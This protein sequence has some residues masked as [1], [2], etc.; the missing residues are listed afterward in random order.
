MA[1][2]LAP[3]EPSVEKAK[4]REKDELRKSIK[5]KAPAPYDED[6]SRTADYDY[7]KYDTILPHDLQALK[8]DVSKQS[9]VSENKNLILIN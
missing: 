3:K 9:Y 2:R 5:F 8:R 6:G 7:V 4:G 1:D